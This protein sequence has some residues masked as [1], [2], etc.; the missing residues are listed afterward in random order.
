MSTQVI[1]RPPECIA[2]EDRNVV[3]KERYGSD[4]ME[5]R[6]GRPMAL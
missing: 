2:R 6:R 1:K 4:E 3:G 5:K